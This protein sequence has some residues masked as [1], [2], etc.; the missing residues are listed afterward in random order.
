MLHLLNNLLYD[1]GGRIFNINVEEHRKRTLNLTYEG[2]FSVPIFDILRVGG[3]DVT[4]KTL[5]ENQLSALLIEVRYY[6]LSRGH[7]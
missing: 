7:I 5:G 1:F 4:G 3:Y 2:E 6:V